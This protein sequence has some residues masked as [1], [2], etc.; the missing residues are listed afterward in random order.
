MKKFWIEKRDCKKSFKIK[1]IDKK[2][3]DIPKGSKMLIVS[4]PIIDEYVKSIHYGEFVE[5]VHMRDTLAE[6]YQADKTCPVTTGIFLRIISEASYEEYNNGIDLGSISPFWRVV[7]PKSKLAKKL[8]CGTDFIA[9]RQIQE[10]II[11]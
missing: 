6:E 7:N 9:E 3:S 4:P 11:L 10:N 8:A 5:P 2:F 1:T